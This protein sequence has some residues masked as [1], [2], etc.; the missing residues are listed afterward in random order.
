MVE[1]VFP[2]VISRKY[3]SLSTFDSPLGYGWSFAHDRSLYEYPDGSVVVRY[4]SGTRDRYTQSGGAFVSPAGGML[5]TLVHNPDG[6]WK[7]SYVEGS[8]DF[9]DSLGRLTATVNSGG[10]RHEFTYD[11]AGK[12]PL[13]GTSPAAATPGTPMVVAYQHRLTRID[14]RG[15][16]G[17]LTGRFATFAYNS[18]TGRLTSV[19]SDDGRTVTYEHDVTASLTKGNLIEVTGLTGTVRAYA[20]AD[21][22]DD[23]NMT[24]ITSAPGQAPV[25]NTYDDQDRVIRQEEGPRKIEFNY[26][27]PL[28]RTVVT[29]TVRDQNGLNPYTAVST[30]DFDATGR[31]TRLQDALGHEERMI[32]NSAK[33]LERKEVWQNNSGTL[34]LLQATGWTYDT[35]GHQ[36]TETTTLDTGEVVTKT[37]TYDH[38]FVA[39]EQTVS[40][41]A[42]AKI[43]R[44]EY[45]FNY[46]GTGRPINVAQQKRRKDDGSFQ[47]TSYTY[48]SR[49][50]LL[51]TTLPDGVEVVNEYTGDF[52]TKRSYRVGGVLIP[53][54]VVR[55]EYNAAGHLIKQWDARNNVTLMTYDPSGRPLT[56]TNPLGE[57]KLWTWDDD[58]L[59]FTESGRTTAD[60]EGQVAKM[61][62][63]TRGL[64]TSLQQKDDAG[65]FQTTHTYEYDSEGQMLSVTD[66]LGRKTK[67]TYD[68]VGR[69]S[70]TTDAS[71]KVTQNSYDAAGRRI[72]ETDALGRQQTFEFDDLNRLV[73]TTNLGVTP[74]VRSEYTYDAVGNLVAFKDPENHTT[75]YTFDALSRNTVITQPLGQTVQFFYD[76]RDRV[77]YLITARGHKVDYDYEPWGPVSRERDYATAGATTPAR[78]ITYA[79]DDDGHI[80]SV[81]DDAIQAG[82]AYA[83]TYDALG[84]LYDETVKY[85]PGGDRVVQERYDR[86]GNRNQLTLQDSGAVTST[87]VYDKRNRLTTATL[88]GSAVSLAYFGS[89]DRQSITF[90]NGAVETFTYKANG[91]HDTLTLTGPGGQLAQSTYAYDDVLNV[92]SETDSLGLHDFGYDGLNRVTQASRPVGSGLPAEAYAYDRAGNREDPGN[93]ALYAYDN[94]NRITASPG[95]TYTWDLDGNAGTRGSETLTHDYRNRLTQF[96]SGSTTT[97]YLYDSFGRRIRKTV[98][99][100]TTWY[101]WNDESLLAE[102]N[103]AGTRTKRYAYLGDDHAPQQVQDSNGTYFVHNDRLQT[104]RF[105]TNSAAAVV[106][107]ASY[108]T[109]GSTT[110][111]EDPDSN[112]V[113]VNMNVRFPGQYFDGES[114][115]HYNHLRQYDPET[116]RYLESDP[117][118]LNGGLNLYRYAYANP[119]AYVDPLGLACKRRINGRSKGRPGK[120][121]TEDLRGELEAGQHIYRAAGQR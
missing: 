86:Y 11:P 109:F 111:N 41:L 118:G 5:A 115:L 114:G 21:P 72:S 59:I 26:Q 99:G 15:T 71:N 88:A 102:F 49:N 85:L 30:Y 43:F 75:T 105:L 119:L 52:V 22:N 10:H 17:A 89:D 74:N 67:Y 112:G 61:N 3:D 28:T 65:V 36:L 116:G 39:S 9:F 68:V 60:G 66:A 16:D 51:T 104:P 97:T 7:L 79:Y 110:P 53:Q 58:D 50:R 46:G 29:I 42:P 84:R 83:I 70:S 57:Q 40:S 107:K 25:V 2:I 13:T 37:W 47:T 27:I 8:E 34:S 23:H 93:S 64:V 87:Y 80:T 33:L 92:D 100:V 91:P 20:Y 90:P 73:A 82:P 120:K 19:T 63:N 38:D 48:D 78:T 6:T 1:G 55:F 18:T 95:R 24:S 45:T 12:L 4:S 98:A 81:T 69:I 113:A 14:E 117:I 31:I 101:L 32:F 35:A 54:A 106:W 94:N 108:T 103:A 44:T 77:D 56:V 62:F 76:N 121:W 96:T